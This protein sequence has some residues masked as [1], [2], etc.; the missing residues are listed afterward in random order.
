[1]E[2]REWAFH[3]LT[4][5]ELHDK[6]MDPGRITDDNP[7]PVYFFDEPMRSNP[8]RLQRRADHGR[9]PPFHLHHLHDARRSCLHR[10]CSHELLAVE[11]LAFAALAYPQAPSSYRKS[12][13]HHLRE[14]Q[15]HVA[16]YR[17]RLHAMGSDLG[18]EAL[19][20][21][22][23]A[24]TGHLHTLD[25]FISFMNLTLEQ[26]NLDFAPMYANSFQRYDPCSAK[27][28]QTI[29]EDEIG[30][31]RLGMYWLKRLHPEKNDADL[32]QHWHDH[33]PVTVE[34]RRSMG[35]VCH[36]APRERAGISNYW[37]DQICPN[38]RQQIKTPV[39][40]LFKAPIIPSSL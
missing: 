7:G 24:A 29:L 3:I 18:D 11:L 20:R 9:L 1:M 21:H 16:I 26:A 2:L 8:L 35:F 5:P 25:H 27:V 39:E 4:S 36:R 22:F 13:I 12:L 34:K 33:L 17:E 6:L 14:E 15:H 38:P 40:F 19:F 23:W 31:V 37:I 30:H 28:M 10:F 32:Y